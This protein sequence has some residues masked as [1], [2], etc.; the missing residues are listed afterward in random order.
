MKKLVLGMV[1]VILPII[2]SF[3][4]KSNSSD[5]TKKEKNKNTLEVKD[6]PVTRQNISIRLI[7]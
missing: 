7:Y 4:F 3:L 2:M 6:K 5:T 1:A